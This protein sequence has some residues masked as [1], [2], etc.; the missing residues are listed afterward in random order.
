M[1]NSMKYSIIRALRDKEFMFSTILIAIL[2]GT[3]MYF[4]TGTM[5]DELNEGTLEIPVAIVEVAGR[6]QSSFIDV[7]ETSQMFNLEFVDREEALYKLEINDVAG[8]FEVGYEPRLLVLTSNFRQ[9][10][11]QAFADEY[12][13]NGDIL[14]NIASENPQ[15]LEATIM[16]MMERVSVMNEMAIADEMIDMMQLS[17]ILFIT[18]TAVSGIFVGFERGI[19]TN[20]D[21]AT[22]S[23]RIMTSFGKVKILVADLVGVAFLVV[24]MTFG[25]WA[26]FAFILGVNL[27]LNVGL[28]SLA[29]F[30]A[31]LFSVS[32]GAFVGLVAPGKRKMREQLL[33]GAYMGMIMLAFF[34]SQLRIDSVELI[35]QFN[36]MSILAD[37]LMALNMGNYVR[38][39]GFIGTIAASTIIFL[40]LAIIS[41]R[42]NR[43]VDTR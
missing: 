33:S 28:A 4:M 41:L 26:Y 42:R 31:S 23:R 13:I 43:H 18:M 32:L 20:N 8:I 24:V 21:G 15:Y 22:A 25:V 10:I 3:V 38:Y 37:T 2:M 34:G 35:N 17:A 27:D 6:E 16:S 11:L 29:F 7:L 9:V 14:A 19:M 39:F 1:F 5:L 12:I 36:P 30:L 40:I